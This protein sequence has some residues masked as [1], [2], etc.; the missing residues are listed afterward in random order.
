MK[1]AITNPLSHRLLPCR[2]AQGQVR[3]PGSKSITNRVLLLSAM[4]EGR[5]QIQNVLQ[6]DDSRHMLNALRMMGVV[7]DQTN[8]QVLINSVGLDRLQGKAL[9]LFLGNS[10]T[11]SRFLCAALC[12]TQLRATLV[13]EPRLYERP[14]AD[15]IRPLL[16]WGAE[17]ECL[18]SPQSL[19]LSINGQGLRGGKVDIRGDK[20][21]QFLTAL[22][23]VAPLTE[24]GAEIV[25][26]GELVSRP[27]IQMTLQLMQAFGV[28]IHHQD[29]MRY[30]IDPQA[31]QSPGRFLIEPDASSASY[32]MA[33]GAIAGGPVR[34][35]GLGRDSIQ[36]DIG[37][38]Q[39]LAQ[40][41]ANVDLQDDYCEVS[42]GD[43]IGVD[44]DLNHIPDAA[45][46]LA[47]VALYAKGTTTIRNIYNWRLKET[48]RLSAV[49]TELKKLG[50]TV[51]TGDDFI[52]ITPCDRIR[53]AEIA[54][55]NDHRMA[56]A[57]SLARF[58]DQEITILDPNCTAKTFP[59]YFQLFESICT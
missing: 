6:S 23:Q 40:M 12:L 52:I 10:G 33:A 27:Y 38:L 48:D 22:L 54:T 21:S 59:G 17:I 39:V 9:E 15:L 14:I 43:L 30:Q 47:V 44:V 37:F 2:H 19:P 28:Q 34:I 55:Y 18:Q 31:Y 51:E 41:G 46:T 5:T 24:Q 45:M 35:E 7:V 36:G 56:M 4:C 25:I 29:L 32:F 26:E 13:G 58:L 57:F 49:A 42:G 16:D 53:Q 11:S 20:S 1:K 50:A 3:V 8:D